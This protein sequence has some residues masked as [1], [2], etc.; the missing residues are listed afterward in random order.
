MDRTFTQ[1][2][3]TL[4]AAV[5]DLPGGLHLDA[6]LRAA[7]RSADPFPLDRPTDV[8]V[9]SLGIEKAFTTLPLTV[10]AGRFY[11]RYD[12]F[13]G[14]WDG[15]NLHVGDREQGVGVAAGFQPSRTD[16]SPSGDLP[17]Y[18]VFGHRAFAVEGARVDAVLLAGQVRPRNDSMQTRTFIGAQQT[19]HARGFALS[20][21]ALLDQDPET[22]EWTFS[23][24]NARINTTISDGLRLR[25]YAR[26]SR[27]Y[28]F[29]GEQ[30]TLL[31][32]TTRFGGGATLLLRSGPLPNTA[33]RADLSTATAEGRPSTLTASGGLSIPR[34]PSTGV[35]LSANATVWTRD[36]VTGTQ[37]GLYG[38]A[39]L[40]RS[41]GSLYARLGY[42]Y[43]QSPLTVGE[44]LVTHGLEA[45]VQVPITR[46]LAFTM[47]AST[48]L[49]DRI[50]STRIYSALWY[51]L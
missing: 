31:D 36:E 46:R 47:Q 25:A 32:R 41:F 40:T 26:S 48:N 5:D 29:F 21:E 24:L 18:T 42:R 22:G 9:Y 44:A 6:H 1:P 14:Y 34:I 51:R 11:N 17:K 27:S 28:L 16:A 23:R 2:F 13:S 45:L 20:T 33:L 15:L 8:R 19:A 35:G 37:R 30:Q 39:G 3:A 49:S 10:T 7:Y 38:S 50:S 12:R 4:R 43:Q